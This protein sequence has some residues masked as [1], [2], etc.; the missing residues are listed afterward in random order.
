MDAG[1]YVVDIVKGE[2]LDL[3]SGKI[4]AT[5]QAVVRFTG[6]D[7]I[8]VRGKLYYV[9]HG[10]RNIHAVAGKMRRRWQEYYDR[11]GRRFEIE[12]RDEQREAAAV[13]TREIEARRLV[14]DAAPDLLAAA[15]R[16]IQDHAMTGDAVDALRAA[17][18]KAEGR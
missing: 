2:G 5:V 10:P 3:R 6:D 13:K 14:R 12:R 18:A 7:M 16:V 8:A 15:K 9:D 17:V 11:T 1:E 4:R